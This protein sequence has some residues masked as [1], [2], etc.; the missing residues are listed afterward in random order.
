MRLPVTDRRPQCG[1]QR[2]QSVPPAAATRRSDNRFCG[3]VALAM[4]ALMLST[5]G[6]TADN[7]YPPPPGPYRIGPVGEVS[8]PSVRR[9]PTPLTAA[10]TRRD[11][12]PSY[13]A[14]TLFGA[15][16]EVPADNI[17][18]PSAGRDPRSLPTFVDRTGSAPAPAAGAHASGQR[19][20]PDSGDA[21]TP[22]GSAPL[23]AENQ[24]APAPTDLIFR[25]ADRRPN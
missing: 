3:L 24:P 8:S 21:A 18:P 15:P 25:P 14:N 19:T 1:L 7:G 10:G 6:N 5:P 13:D 9:Q 17:R 2:R 23:R 11:T 22:A 4:A 20:W 12:P 16:R